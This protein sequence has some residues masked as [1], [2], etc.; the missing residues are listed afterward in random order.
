MI[1]CV[2]YR[3]GSYPTKGKYCHEMALRILLA[4]I[5][6]H[7]MIYKFHCVNYVSLP[8]MVFTKSVNFQ[9]CSFLASS[10]GYL[11]SLCP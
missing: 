2:L 9:F 3:Y 5:E 1:I 6:V 10:F 4:S 8:L 11:S 7:K